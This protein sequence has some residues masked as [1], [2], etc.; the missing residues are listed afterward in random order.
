MFSCSFFRSENFCREKIFGSKFRRKKGDK[1]KSIERE[2]KKEKNAE[3]NERERKKRKKKEGEREREK[4]IKGKN[5]KLNEGQFRN[6]LK[7]VLYFFPFNRT[8]FLNKTGF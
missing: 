1:Q 6:L 4:E 7:C 8:G 3:K 2:R 5:N